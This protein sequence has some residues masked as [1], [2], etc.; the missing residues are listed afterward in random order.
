MRNIM[1][2]NTVHRSGLRMTAPMP[3]RHRTG[4]ATSDLY[5][6]SL[7]MTKEVP[8]SEKRKEILLVT[9]NS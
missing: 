3:R 4:K 2:P 9:C 1:E 8:V 6:P 5:R 7:R